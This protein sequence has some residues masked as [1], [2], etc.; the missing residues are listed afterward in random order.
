MDLSHSESLTL[1]QT[2]GRQI[3]FFFKERW[4]NFKDEVPL[5]FSGLVFGCFFVLFYFLMMMIY[6]TGSICITVYLSP[7]YDKMQDK[8]K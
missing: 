6:F 3:F 4:N 7:C 5:V 1:S 2:K 8:K